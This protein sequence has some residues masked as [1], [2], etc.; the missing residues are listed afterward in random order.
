MSTWFNYNM[1]LCRNG[2]SFRKV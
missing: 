2:N 1:M